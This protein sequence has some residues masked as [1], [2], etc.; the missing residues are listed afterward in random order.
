MDATTAKTV[1]DIIAL[2]GLV[3]LVAV[4][5]AATRRRLL[6]PL[7][8]FVFLFFVA[9][10]ATG[11]LI[12]PP[13]R[14]MGDLQK[15]MYVHV[16]SAWAFM[17][18]FF[19]VFV[20]SILYLWRRQVHHDRLAA[21]AAEAGAVLTGLAL[22]QG[23]IWG[24]PTWGVWW[25][26][27]PRIAFTTV[28]LM[29]FAGYIALRAF[30]D[31]EERRARWS[32]AVGIVGALNVPVVYMSVRW[33]RTLHQPQSTPSTVDPAYIMGLRLNAFAF[34]FLLLFLVALRYR[35]MM[36][37]RKADAILEDRALKEDVAHV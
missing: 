1:G 11:L 3:L 5:W 2:A 19:M 20:A 16:P 18:A 26:P 4:G 23:M 22:A 9:S 6:A 7:G 25:T 32:A 33:W 17:I 31:D 14:G 21:A 27:D 15:I 8:V 24:K 35:A 37:D 34:L 10:Q 30:T 36:A 13:E 28:V 29:I 12:S